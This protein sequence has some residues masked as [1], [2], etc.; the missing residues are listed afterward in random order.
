MPDIR[1]DTAQSLSG[2]LNVVD[3]YC[4]IFPC[5]V[6]SSSSSVRVMPGINDQGEEGSITE[7][8]TDIHLEVT[9]EE[10]VVRRTPWEIL[11]WYYNMLKGCFCCC[12]RRLAYETVEPPSESD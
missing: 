6:V 3:F 7:E 10:F 11:K 5:Q 8:I 1:V 2:H 9:Y 4:T 12:N